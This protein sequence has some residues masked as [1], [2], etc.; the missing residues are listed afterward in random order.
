MSYLRFLKPKMN[1]SHYSTIDVATFL[2]LKKWFDRSSMKG[3]ASFELEDQNHFVKKVSR[4]YGYA[5]YCVLDALRL[6]EEAGFISF[7][8]ERPSFL[9]RLFRGRRASERVAKRYIQANKY[10]R[11]VY[12]DKPLSSFRDVKQE[13]S[14]S[15]YAK[16]QGLWYACD[17]DWKR[18]VQS[19]MP[20]WAGKYTH[21]YLLD[22]NL[23]RMCVIRTDE[24]MELF[25][26]KYLNRETDGI[27]WIAVARDYDGIEI[28]PYRSR[29]R[30]GYSWYYT[31]DVASG[32]IWGRGAFKGVTEVENDIGDNEFVWEDDDSWDDDSWDDDRST[33]NPVDSFQLPQRHQRHQLP[34]R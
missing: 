2:E 16:P 17:K 20:D 6:L 23:R 32:C 5:E 28:C 34:Q 19:E 15:P 21:K 3:V 26:V 13:R 7:K 33:N 25:H 4:K 1:I 22:V 18:F 9:S 29:F 12:S 27:D 10:D 30:M 11:I 31:W 24:D 8:S 14:R